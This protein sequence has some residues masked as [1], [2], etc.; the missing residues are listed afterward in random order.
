MSHGRQADIHHGAVVLGA[1]V[2]YGARGSEG[3]LVP[4]FLPVVKSIG[5]GP[6]RDV[7]RE[8]VGQLAQIVVAVESISRGSDIVGNEA[9]GIPLVTFHLEES[10]P[11]VLD[12]SDVGAGV[13]PVERPAAGGDAALQRLGGFAGDHVDDSADGVGTV[14]GR[15]SSLYD[16][17][18]LEPPNR[19]AI[20]IEDAALDS[21][22]A[23]D[24]K[25]VDQDQRLAGIDSLNLGLGPVAG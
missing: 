6:E 25:S 24:R 16:L 19:L 22:G 18:A 4:P 15:G 1:V 10:A 14:E 20:H 5:H 13:E 3:S 8:L 21:L 23:H 12:E 7:F 17:N 9:V 11:L 2:G